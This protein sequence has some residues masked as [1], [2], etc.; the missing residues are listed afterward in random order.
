ML[1]FFFCLRYSQLTMMIFLN[2]IFALMFYYVLVFYYV[3]L[4]ALFI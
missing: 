2:F 4:C 1:L 3:F